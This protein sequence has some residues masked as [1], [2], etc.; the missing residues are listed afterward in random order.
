MP[1][2]TKAATCHLGMGR[3]PQTAHHCTTCLTDSIILWRTK[4]SISLHD[5]ARLSREVGKANP[6]TTWAHPGSSES[7]TKDR[8]PAQNTLLYRIQ[9]WQT[10]IRLNDYDV[11]VWSGKLRH[12]LY[13]RFG[14]EFCLENSDLATSVPGTVGSSHLSVQCA[15]VM[16]CTTLQLALPRS[17]FF[18][19]TR[20]NCLLYEV[21][22]LLSC[23]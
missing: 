19:D 1:C 13:R 3:R 12:C 21:L 9:T 5:W 22:Q 6:P 18:C 8:N 10:T 16:N 11:N 17:L 14:V 7:V 4:Q 23:S 20:I 15:H 2:G